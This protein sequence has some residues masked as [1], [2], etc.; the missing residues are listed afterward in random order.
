MFEVELEQGNRFTPTGGAFERHRSAFG[1]IGVALFGQSKHGAAGLFTEHHR[2][3]R[4]CIATPFKDKS[5]G[6]YRFDDSTGNLQGITVRSP[7][8][9]SPYEGAA[10]PWIKRAVV[11]EERVPYFSGSNSVE[12]LLGRLLNE[13]RLLDRFL[14]LFSHGGESH[15]DAT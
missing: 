9:P 1:I 12:H 5:F 7:V 4:W 2:S 8:F 11:R 3:P 14:E 15:V 10:G 6:S 13:C